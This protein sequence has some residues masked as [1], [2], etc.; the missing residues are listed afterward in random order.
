M[1]K[2]KIFFT[3]QTFKE[4]K[5]LTP[6][7]KIKLKTILSEVLSKDPFCGKK[8]CGDLSGNY[9]YRLDLKNRIIYS[10]DKKKRIIYVKRTKTH[11]GD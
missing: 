8:L 9:S 7:L 4:V 2:Y 3:K 1:N 10:I 11:Y 6:K 5:S